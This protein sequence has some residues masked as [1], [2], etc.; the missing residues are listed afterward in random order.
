[1]VADWSSANFENMNIIHDPESVPIQ[2]WFDNNMADLGWT[3]HQLDI[4]KKSFDIIDKNTD[5]E[6]ITKIWQ[7]LLEKADL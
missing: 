1:M 3:D 4:I 2:K 5:I 7:P 6:T